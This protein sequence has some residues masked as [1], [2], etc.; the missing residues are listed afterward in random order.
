MPATQYDSLDAALDALRRAGKRPVYFHPGH[1]TGD[2]THVGPALKLNAAHGVL[3]FDANNTGGRGRRQ[4]ADVLVDSYRVP[5]AQVAYV[6]VS[7]TMSVKQVKDRLNPKNHRRWLTL[8]ESTTMVG[9]AL[10]AAATAGTV[11]QTLR[12][13]DY[14]PVA[15][16]LRR[17][18]DEQLERV[19]HERLRVPLTAHVMVLWGRR[20]GATGGL[21]PDQDHNAAFMQAL[22]LQGVA[23]GWTVLL[24]GDFDPAEH[25]PP[26]GGAG[27]FRFLGKFWAGVPVLDGERL[28]QT[29]MFYLLWRDL[30]V[31]APAH[32]LVH[33]GMRSGGLDAYGFSGQPTLYL[34]GPGDADLRMSTKVIDPM[35]R[36]FAD[37]TTFRRLVLTRDPR[38]R[39][40]GNWVDAAHAPEDVGA[41][42]RVAQA[43]M[44][45]GG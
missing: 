13:A 11:R 9:Q 21:H 42:M 44:L 15:G 36:A 17:S 32:G 34:I 22:A 33:V 23:A 5:T 31:C 29:R 12:G 10:A 14:D 6:D 16:I 4:I 2:V 3:V 45:T 39:V 18:T 43:L 1:S 37:G 26:P 24:A 27:A 7:A 38:R 8:G 19:L 28:N 25:P 20:S 41:A 30:K 35:Q 40:G